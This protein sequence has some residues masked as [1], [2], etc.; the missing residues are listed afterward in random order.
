MFYYM[1]ISVLGGAILLADYRYY[2][3]E[4]LRG[5]RGWE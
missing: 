2:H 5:S 3:A 1:S 4:M